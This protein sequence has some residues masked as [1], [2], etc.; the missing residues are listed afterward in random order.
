MAASILT[1]KIFVPPPRPQ[2]VPRHRLI[3]RLNA[4]FPRKL[5]LVSAPAGF[6]KTT[7]I[8][9]WIDHLRLTTD[10]L[11]LEAASQEKIVNP[12]SKIVNQVAWLS[13]DD[14]DNEL[15]RFLTYLV[16]AF[17]QIEPTLGAMTLAHLSAPEPP[18]PET[19]LIALVNELSAFSEKLLLVLDDY[20]LITEQAVHSAVAFL[21]SHQPPNLHLIMTSR[22]DPPLP[23]ARL[24]VRRQL[25]ELRAADLRFTSTEI[26]HF[27][28]RLVRL[29][30][31]PAMRRVLETRTEGWVAGLQLAALSLSGK[32]PQRIDSFIEAFSGSHRYVLDY[33]AEEVLRQQPQPVQAFLLQTSILERLCGPLCDAV[34]E[35]REQRS[36]TKPTNEFPISSPQSLVSSLQSPVSNLQSPSPSQSIL[37]YLDQ[38]NLFLIPLDDQR[39]WYRYH[40]LFAEFLQQQLK[41]SMD[42]STRLEGYRRAAEWSAQNGWLE[43]AIGYALAAH[44]W[45]QAA[46]WVEQVAT[47]LWQTGQTGQL[48]ELVEALPHE[49]RTASPQLCLWN[50]MALVI[51]GRLEEYHHPLAMAEAAWQAADNTAQLGFVYHTRALAAHFQG[52]SADALRYAELALRHLPADSYPY[53]GVQWYLKARSQL[54][55]GQLQTAKQTLGQA[56]HIS[57]QAAVPRITHM[58]D[59][60]EADVLVIEGKLQPALNR[61]QAAFD[62]I[63]PRW[64]LLYALVRQRLGNLYLE[65]DQPDEGHR[66]L[67]EALTMANDPDRRHYGVS[68]YVTMAHLCWAVGQPEDALAHIEQAALCAQRFENPYALAQVD[69]C[70]ALIRLRQGHLAAAASWAVERHLSPMMP[71]DYERQAESLTFV[72]LLIA[73]AKPAEALHLLNRLITETEQ[74]GRT[75]HLVE[76]F[77]LQALAHQADHNLDRALPALAQALALG[78]AGG[79]RRTFIDEGQPMAQLLTAFSRRPTGISPAYLSQ[80]LAACGQT[81]EPPSATPAPQPLLEPLSER[82]LDVLRL[83]VSGATNKEIASELVIA[84]NTVKK[85]TTNIFGKL[86]VSNR[87]QAVTRARELGLVGG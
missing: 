69:A 45:E 63:K 25:N 11:Q 58:V 86:G 66:C 70:R 82:E 10:D 85:H 31:S 27:F 15:T 17:Q 68:L 33:L 18:L 28:E 53:R 32:D 78:Q 21:L 51:A 60:C 81:G 22:A 7:L 29:S 49:V 44:E 20:H 35:N 67:T 52:Y 48:L 57:R 61:Y 72:R 19:L 74:A 34:V 54:T 40:P 83:I 50:A 64:S 38:A 84:V 87:L 71:L 6:G 75:G 30:L 39:Q 1:T 73:Q 23:L 80:L 37:E 26:D 43:N 55:M 8:S 9:S 12:K 59:L 42:A 16:A 4:G 36:E 76:L 47:P 77:A 2:L 46:T 79:Y 65:L 41:S 56:R 14:T 13:L 24:R 3:E 62:T 5:T